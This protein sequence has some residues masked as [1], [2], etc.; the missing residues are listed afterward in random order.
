[1]TITTQAAAGT[2]AGEPGT[3]RY[4]GCGGPA[5][6]RDHDAPGRRPGYCGREVPE[7]R[8]DGTMVPVRHTALAAF[9]RRQQL[10]GQ[11]GQDRP[12]TAAISRAGAIRDDA[13]AAMTRL[14]AQLAAAL[15]QLAVLGGQLAAAGDPE[16]AEA[17]AEAVRAETAAQLEQARAGTAA[18]AAAR[19]AAELGAA[20]ARA[21]AAEAITEMETQ[22]RAR[23]QAEE[24]AR[25]AARERDGQR[26]AA[27]AAIAAA[28]DARRS[29]ERRS[30]RDRQQHTAELAASAARLTAANDTITALRGQLARTE[31]ALERER[32]EQHKTV[33]LLHGLITGRQQPAADDPEPAAP[34]GSARR[35]PAR[36]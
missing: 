21:A 6:A 29:A 32:A 25:G 35:Q 10:A 27:A 30:E 34:A 26:A 5:R 36:R 2:M 8:G 28:E 20:E 33:A 17:Q 13:L 9:R 16:A 14:S 23:Q 19:H 7:D 1:M 15:D 4:P 3:C 24:L 18:C 12:V 31:T 11:P 22:A